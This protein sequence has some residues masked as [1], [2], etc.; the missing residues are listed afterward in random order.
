V[1][2]VSGSERRWVLR[3]LLVAAVGILLG[4]LGPFGTFSDLS[5]GERYSYWVG[6][7]LL[8]WLQGIAVLALVDRPLAQRGW[9]GWGRVVVSALVA[10]V[11]TGFEVAWAEMFL[12]VERD[13]GPI[14]VLAIIGDVALLSVPL[15]LLTHG[16]T[17]SANQID[18]GSAGEASGTDSLIALMEPGKR[19]PLLA[20]GSEDHY[21]RLYSDRGDS[22]VAMRFADA[23]T[24]LAESEGIQV[25]RS[26]WVA[27]GAVEA[28]NR[29]GEGLQLTLRNGLKVPVSRSFAQQ[30]RKAWADRMA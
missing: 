30:V 6:L 10:A 14:D 28:V 12:R 23:V 18:S 22:L 3:L 17:H 8:M 11:P 9:P 26:W 29:A 1:N 27:A 5:S 21:V 4:R 7:T 15:L 13:L 25:H 24:A 16:L 19:G 2:G 20:M